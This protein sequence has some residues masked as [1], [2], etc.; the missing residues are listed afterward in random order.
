M[1]S[2]LGNE[3]Q[4]LNSIQ[5]WEIL[6]PH[7]QRHGREAL[8]YATLQPGM[9]YFIHDAGFLAFTTAIHPVFARKPKRIVLSDPVC[10][11]N[12]LETLLGDFLSEH[13]RAI[14]AVASEPCAKVLRE[15]GFKVNCV[16]YEPELPIQTYNTRGNWKELDMIKRARNEAKRHQ[17]EI[18][19]VDI[20]TIPIPELQAI[21]DG[22]IEGKKVSDREIWV[23]A[24]RPVYAEEP[25]VRK[26]VAFDRHGVPVG[27][28]FYDPM[29]RDGNVIGY[30]A[31]TVRCNERTY[32][33]LATAIHMTAMEVFREEGVETL[34]LCLC[35]FTDIEKG[36]FSDD[37]AT[38]WFFK[39]SR[40]Y[41]G[42]IYNFDG[43][44]FHK[45]KYRGCRKPLYY[46]SNS[47]I[48]ANDIYLAFL[49][50][51]IATSYW[52]TMGR[53]ALGVMKGVFPVRKKM[54]PPSKESSVKGSKSES[55]KDR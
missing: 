43:L 47:A 20:S 2:I 42:E 1:P 13:P 31:N 48:P 11:I 27:Y 22:W 52:S 17:L 18:R 21:S 7:I 29:H 44:S 55:C 34:N 10:S 50:S 24:R 33:R 14:F 51:D 19:E 38:K 8:S 9:E 40:Q 35:P 28:V 16:G 23:Y 49:T 41:G 26:F 54:R 5:K 39:I 15:M 32:G 3:A 53:L 4:R 12:D 46:A 36:C 30:S 37:L 6:G 25:G 45:S